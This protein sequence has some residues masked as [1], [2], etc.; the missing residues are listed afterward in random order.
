VKAAL[1]DRYGGNDAVRVADVD[2]PTVGAT[3]LL[4]RVHAASVNPV[5]VKTH[6]GKLK[7]LLKYRWTP[8]VWMPEHRAGEVTY[9]SGVGRTPGTPAG[10]SAH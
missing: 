3:D 9:Y 1:I 8:P 7:T 2:V 4:V 5:D 10:G 6:E